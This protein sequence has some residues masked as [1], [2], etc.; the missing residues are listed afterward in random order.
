[1]STQGGR[2]GPFDERRKPHER[3]APASLVDLHPRLVVLIIAAEREVIGLE[4][5]HSTT[6]SFGTSLTNRPR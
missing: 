3:L 2:S 4:R 1:L 6:S 5:V